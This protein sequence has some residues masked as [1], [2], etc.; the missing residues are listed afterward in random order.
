[1]K[2]KWNWGT[3]IALFYVVFVLF[4]LGN[5]IFSSTIPINLVAE[6]YYVQEL[7]YQDKI[8][9]IK[10]TQKL[11]EQPILQYADNSFLIK[12]PSLFKSE[13]IKGDLHFYRPS[14]SKL[15]KIYTLKLT[16][17]NSQV[18]DISTLKPGTWRAKLMWEAGDKSYYQ[19]S[20]FVK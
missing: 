4:M 14:D 3:G 20:V 6:D 8:E 7:Q 13:D 11:Q 17:A 15:D 10:N 19:E 16:P 1:M 12:L 5:L 2:L 18:F 9:M